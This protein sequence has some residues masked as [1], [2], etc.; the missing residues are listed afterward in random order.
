MKCLSVMMRYD[1]DRTN[2]VPKVKAYRSIGF[3]GNVPG[4]EEMLYLERKG[5]D[6][7]RDDRDLEEVFERVSLFR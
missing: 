7:D 2:P 6:L 5:G 1:I 3:E 4:V